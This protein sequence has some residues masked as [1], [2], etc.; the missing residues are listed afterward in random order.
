MEYEPLDVVYDME[1]A[2]GQDSPSAHINLKNNIALI[3]RLT[4][5]N[6]EAAFKN[7]F[8]TIKVK[9]LN[10]RLSPAPLETRSCLADYSVASNTLTFWL[11]TQSP[12]SARTSLSNILEIPENKIRVIGPDVGG[13]FGAKIRF[14]LKT[15][16]L[17]FHR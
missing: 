4:Y 12:F 2:L 10:Q 5:G 14:I 3:D 9:H 17:V 8:K 16:F 11:S 1:K 6:V 15:F 7:A 13:G